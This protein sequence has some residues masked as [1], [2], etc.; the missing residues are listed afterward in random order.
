M[1]RRAAAL[2]KLRE[3]DPECLLLS[4]GDFY[5][6]PGI[7]EMY[8]SRFLS[9]MMVRMGYD[10]VAVGERELNYGLR[11]IQADAKAGLPAICANLYMNGERLF[12]PYK[13]EFRHGNKVGI[14]ALLGESPRDIEGI[15]VRD[16]GEEGFTVLHDLMDQKCDITI[17]LAHMSREKL[18]ELL[19]S[20]QGTD[21]VVRGHAPAESRTTE[22]CADTLGGS[23]ED[24]AVPIVF[25]GDRGRSL[26]K[27][28]IAP[29]EGAP[30]I[31]G[32]SVVNLDST[33]EEDRE[34]AAMLKTFTEEEGKRHREM[35]MAEF[36]SRDEVSGKV[37]ERYLGFDVCMRCHADL[38]PRF[39]ES[40]HFRA[41]AV[42][43][44]QDQSENEKCLPCHTTG[45]ARFSG[46]DPLREEEGGIYLQGVQCEACHGPGTLHARDGSYLARAWKSCTE[47]H[48]NA[49]SPGFDP[50]TYWNRVAHCGPRAAATAAEHE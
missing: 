27:I 21:L 18:S 36:L 40:R 39:I 50:E 45:Y 25:A 47:C 29:G 3:E 46:Y 14:Y 16:P 11:A 9:E 26:G 31:T 12:P 23:F 1:A 32:R 24:S 41:F 5:G 42:L 4:A 10:A 28:I 48:T 2:K 49:W 43:E 30:V 33:V 19:P 35:R 7:I 22:D 13:I 17:L 6:Q 34:T 38:M 8:R 37:R 15:E 20:F 44:L